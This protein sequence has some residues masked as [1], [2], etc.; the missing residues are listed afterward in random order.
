MKT[1]WFPLIRPAINTLGGRLLKHIEQ[2]QQTPWSIKP[3]PFRV[4]VTRMTLDCNLNPFSCHHYLWTRV[5]E[6]PQKQRKKKQTMQRPSHASMENFASAGSST[7]SAHAPPVKGVTWRD[8]AQLRW[9][10]CYTGILTFESYPPPKKNDRWSEKA[11]PE[12]QV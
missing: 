2:R 10:P 9:W 11:V 7:K 6:T 8:R 1:Y 3:S 12:N 4:R 5:V